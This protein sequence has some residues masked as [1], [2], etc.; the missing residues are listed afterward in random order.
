MDEM[1]RYIFGSLR[2]SETAIRAMSKTI[3]KQRSF[4][5]TVTLFVVIAAVSMTIH[6]Y[7]IRYLNGQIETLKK[8]IKE[9][10]QTE[11]D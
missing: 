4:N 10:K 7:E 6:E 1:I 5:N 3:R 8:E 11:G 2:C 9:L